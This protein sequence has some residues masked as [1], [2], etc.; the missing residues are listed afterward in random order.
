MKRVVTT[1]LLLALIIT[2]GCKKSEKSSEV[3][4]PYF[5]QLKSGDKVKILKTY[6]NSFLGQIDTSYG[7]VYILRVTGNHYQMGY[8]YG[9]LAG[10]MI[11][12][13][14][15]TFVNYLSS[16]AEQVERGI[17]V[18]MGMVSTLLGRILDEAWKHM[19][20]YVPPYFMD[21]IRGIQ[22]GARDA[23][24]KNEYMVNGE[25]YSD[26]DVDFATMVKRIIAISNISDISE[27]DIMEMLKVIVRGYSEK[28]AEY[29]HLL[30]AVT[31]SP[32]ER[33]LMESVASSPFSL[34]PVPRIF[35]NCSFFAAYNYLTEGGHMIA[36]RNLDWSNG[37]GI[38]KFKTLTIWV[39]E[40]GVPHM[41]IGYTGFIGALAGF[42]AAGIGLGEVGSGS[43]LERLDGEPWVLKFRDILQNAHNLDEALSYALNRAPDGFNRPPTIGYNWMIAYG[44]P[45]GNGAGAEVA[46]LENNGIFTGVYRRK[47]DCSV[48]ASLIEFG[49]D[50][51]IFRIFTHR[52]HPFLVNYEGQAVE[53]MLG[54]RK[55]PLN[56]TDIPADYVFPETKP[57]VMIGGR[58]RYYP[59]GAS[60]V[61]GRPITCAVFRGDEMM[62]HGMRMW[63]T[64]ASGPWTYDNGKPV[65]DLDR[66]LYYAGSY[67]GRYMRMYRAIYAYSHGIEYRG[68]DDITGKEKIIVPDNGGKLLK[69]GLDE[70]ANI[71]S[72]AAMHCC[73]VISVAYDLTA[74]KAK[75]AYETGTGSSW[76]N[77]ADNEYHLFDL[78]ELINLKLR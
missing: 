59:G 30:T 43:V 48:E 45:D 44:D 17:N 28:Y 3:K 68:T 34:L 49:P 73:N 62:I 74:L 76:K 20:P 19:E 1:L 15:W 18:S 4:T 58:Y 65:Q 10:Y 31:F 7:P 32:S 21:E 63:Q 72:W 47:P 50:G 27:D 29:F 38:A 11:P 41:T 51:R 55:Y 9:R 33:E 60:L 70:G 25:Y 22:D 5:L 77:A 23:G 40:K 16:Q 57:V 36:S 66:L 13:I 53:I 37:S 12:G 54:N 56:I 71:A 39:P 78:R 69:I 6:G 52:D 35:H 42:N 67:N 26:P 2:A 61:V 75:I 24:Y 64:A 8:A 14:W 46:N